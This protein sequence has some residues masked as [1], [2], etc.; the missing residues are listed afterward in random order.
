MPLEQIDQFRERKYGRVT[1]EYNRDG[2]DDD[3]KRLEVACQIGFRWRR[4]EKGKSEVY[5][6]EVFG[7]LCQDG[8]EVFCCAL[9]S[10]RHCMI[11]VMF[12]SNSA[13]Q[14]RDDSGHRKTVGEEVTGV[15]AQ[16]DQA[17]LDLRE[18]VEGRVLER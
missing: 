4:R 5:E 6:D 15:R 18:L 10:S 3:E 16:R 11:C 17:G 14:Q 8:E 2:G 1:D 12:K 7:K 9:C 13:E